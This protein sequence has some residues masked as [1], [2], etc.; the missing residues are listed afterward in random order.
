MVYRQNTGFQVCI[1]IY[2]WMGTTATAKVPAHPSTWW[3]VLAVFTRMMMMMI[4]IAAH[5]LYLSHSPRH[6]GTVHHH[7]STSRLLTRLVF[8][9]S[10]FYYCYYKLVCCYKFKKESDVFFFLNRGNST[11]VLLHATL[12]HRWSRL[13]EHPVTLSCCQSVYVW[14]QNDKTKSFN[15]KLLL[16]RQEKVSLI[17]ENLHL[18]HEN[19]TEGAVWKPVLDSIV[20]C[21]KIVKSNKTDLVVW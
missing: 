4:T 8:I 5:P 19:K 3:R 6:L 17:I 7:E 14:D 20:I 1:V 12:Y 16:M 2:P 18:V 15:I 13:L 9:I 10:W 11:H 21:W